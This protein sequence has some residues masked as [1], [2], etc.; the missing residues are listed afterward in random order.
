MEHKASWYMVCFMVIL[1]VVIG[2]AYSLTIIDRT[3]GECMM[4]EMYMQPS[5]MHDTISEYCKEATK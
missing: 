1:F 4:D 3:Y 2:A 5:S